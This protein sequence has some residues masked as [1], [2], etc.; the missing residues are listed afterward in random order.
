MA[1]LWE[2]SLVFR[3][4]DDLTDGF[5]ISIR[6][7]NGILAYAMEYRKVRANDGI[8]Q[9]LGSADRVTEFWSI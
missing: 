1:L 5:S 3:E 4:S 2:K 8:S 7:G 6:C 9:S